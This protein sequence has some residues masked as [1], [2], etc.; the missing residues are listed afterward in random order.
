MLGKCIIVFVVISLLFVLFIFQVV[1]F[2]DVE[3]YDV[4]FFLFS[5][6]MFVWC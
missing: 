6:K 1:D 4:L 2:F 3:M 5:S